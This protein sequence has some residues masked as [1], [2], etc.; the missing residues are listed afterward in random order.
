MRKTE[1]RSIVLREPGMFHL[2]ETWVLHF[3]ILKKN[4]DLT[5]AIYQTCRDYLAT[6]E[7]DQLMIKHDDIIS[8]KVFWEEVPNEI[9]Q[10][11]GFE[12]QKREIIKESHDWD[13]R[14][15]PVIPY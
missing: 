8:W 15:Y 13:E 5:N 7:G 12:K 14:I 2:A 1:K 6:P 11:Y 4:L 3:K 9:C 10:K